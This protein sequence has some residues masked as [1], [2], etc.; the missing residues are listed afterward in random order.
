MSPLALSRHQAGRRLYN[1]NAVCIQ[2]KNIESFVLTVWINERPKRI[3]EPTVAVQLLLVLF[4]ET[5]NDLDRAR[6]R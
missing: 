2:S 1:T 3:E 5:E 4:L 6:A